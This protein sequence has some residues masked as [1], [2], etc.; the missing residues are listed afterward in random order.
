MV[1]QGGAVGDARFADLKAHFPT[2]EIVEIIALV[3]IMELASS[4]GAVF[5]LEPDNKPDG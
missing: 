5:G 1:A 2:G 3:G 4:F